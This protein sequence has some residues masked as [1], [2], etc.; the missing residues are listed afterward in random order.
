MLHGV[1]G[2][3][4]Q[5]HTLL[6]F[7]GKV[8]DLGQQMDWTVKDRKAIRDNQAY[9]LGY[10]GWCTYRGAEQCYEFHDLNG[11]I[12]K[13]DFSFTNLVDVVYAVAR[14]DDKRFLII[15]EWLVDKFETNYSYVVTTAGL[16]GKDE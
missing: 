7:D 5:I 8:T 13:I 15:N 2:T 4:D 1:C 11:R 10:D 6:S 9:V 3:V 14:F 12:W 16:F